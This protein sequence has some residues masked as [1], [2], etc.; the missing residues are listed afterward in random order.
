M[1]PFQFRLSSFSNSFRIFF[2]AIAVWHRLS[3]ILLQNQF[4]CQLGSLRNLM[5]SL[6]SLLKPSVLTPK[7]RTARLYQC[8]PKKRWKILSDLR[9]DSI[10]C[11]AL[12]INF[13]TL[14]GGAFYGG[15]LRHNCFNFNFFLLRVNSSSRNTREALRSNHG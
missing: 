14:T 12:P 11:I 5:I 13:I 2:I 9:F 4:H 15:R 6:K 1:I 7:R 3:G 8:G 10:H